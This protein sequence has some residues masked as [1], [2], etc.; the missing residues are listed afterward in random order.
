MSSWIKRTFKQTGCRQTAAVNKTKHRANTKV[1]TWTTIICTLIESET[2]NQQQVIVRVFS[3]V[4]KHETRKPEKEYNSPDSENPSR[5]PASVELVTQLSSVDSPWLTS[6]AWFPKKESAKSSSCSTR[7]F[8]ICSSKRV[9][10]DEWLKRTSSSMQQSN[11]VR[12]TSSPLHMTSLSIAG[13]SARARNSRANSESSSSFEISSS[14][15]S[16]ARQC[17]YFVVVRVQS[18]GEN[19]VGVFGGVGKESSFHIFPELERR[20]S[21]SVFSQSEGREMHVS[22]QSEISKSILR[23]SPLTPVRV[24]RYGLHRYW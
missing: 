19:S 15:R 4:S 9:G 22:F 18:G 8:E 16:C 10:V 3:S 2:N 7:L 14:L 12:F 23:S 20:N 17:S 6:A 13:D 21:S 11:S 5:P 24:A 1:Q